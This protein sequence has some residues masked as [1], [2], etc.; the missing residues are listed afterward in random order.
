MAREYLICSDVDG[1]LIGDSQALETL[2]EWLAPRRDQIK[3]VYNSGRTIESLRQVVAETAL[4]EP[5]ALVGNVG[6]EIHLYREN[7]TLSTWPNSSGRWSPDEVREALSGFGELELQPDMF[8]A[9]HKV[10][11]FV[12]DAKPTDL[13]NWRLALAARD[14]DMQ[15]VYSSDRDLDVLPLGVDK[16]SA[17]AYLATLWQMEHEQVIVCGDTGNDLSMFEQGYYGIVVG[18]AMPELRAFESPRAYHA[19]G[20]LAAGVQEGLEHWLQQIAERAESLAS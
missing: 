4:P 11:Y 2:A 19:T 14:L 18:N 12:Y 13:E 5:D 17:T 10:S 16:G 3:L 8:Q 15:L 6:T 9:P 20:E 1:T 7:Q